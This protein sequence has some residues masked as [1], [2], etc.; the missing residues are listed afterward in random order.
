MVPRPDFASYYGR[1]II[2]EPT[3]QAADI[4]GYLFLGGLA[5]A[6]AVL[7]EGAAL[8][9]RSHLA[10]VARRAA[11]GAAGLGTVALVHD[12][13]RP[14]RF[15]N[16][17]RVFK[18][19]S[20]M[21]V[22]SFVLAPFSAL[23]T[24]AVL[25]DLTGVMPRAGRAAGAAA[26]ALGPVLATYTAA[27]VGDTAVP[28]WHN[29]YKHLPFVFAGSG[30]YA[31]G[32]LAMALTPVA[33]SGPALRMALGGAMVEGAAENLMRMQLGHAGEP[34]RRGRAGTLRQ[35][36]RALTVGG[37]A[38]SVLGRRSRLARAVS[39]AAYVAGSACLRLGIFEAGVESARDPRYTV[40]PQRRR[41]EAAAAMRNSQP[42]T[43]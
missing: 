31:A 6:S 10:A 26:A 11:A 14:S 35:A 25:S 36:A 34:Y 40:E 39:G 23:S 38:L 27:L 29:A 28:A 41:L 21:S 15:L 18:P 16:M 2:K 43:G 20:P 22:G 37:A 1:P 19:T 4:A 8:T 33:E 3:W 7:A 5:G 24:A 13:G 32:G 9:G 17:L 12:L 30:C 42:A